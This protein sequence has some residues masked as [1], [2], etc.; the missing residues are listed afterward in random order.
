M[1]PDQINRFVNAEHHQ[2]RQPVRRTTPA[3]ST[4]VRVRARRHRG[5]VPSS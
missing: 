5:E 2:R 3:L 4:L 1:D